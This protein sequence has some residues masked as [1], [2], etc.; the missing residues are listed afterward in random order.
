MSGVATFSGA[1]LLYVSGAFFGRQP[2]KHGGECH[3]FAK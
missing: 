1:Q 3:E 2:D